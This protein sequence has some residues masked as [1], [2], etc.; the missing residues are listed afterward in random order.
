MERMTKLTTEGYHPDTT[1][2]DLMSTIEIIKLMNEEDKKIPLAIAKVL[3]EIEQA[4]TAVVH[5]LKSGGRL[6]YVGAGTSGR[7]GLLDA[8]E[9][10]P[11]F[12]T[13]PKLVQAILAGGANA[14]MI[15]IEGAE[16][17]LSLGAVELQ[18][19][20]LTNRDVVIGI[21]ASGRTPF[22]KGALIYAQQLG[23]KTISLV[24]NAHS[25]ISEHADIAIEVI[26][27]PEILTGST[28]LK[29]AT[30][31]KQI[32]NMITTTTMIKLGKVYKNL[33]VDVHASNF[34]L[35]ERAKHIVCE[36]TGASYSQAES[37]LEQNNYQVKLAIVVLL[38]NTTIEEATEL[39][40]QAEGHV[41]RAVELRKY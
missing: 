15:A 10:P 20:Q 11:T 6:F 39:L 33:M 35:R 37:V 41:R 34:K 31:H 36:V 7:I 18:K 32:L 16:D 21:A 5:A 1:N 28:R 12:S 13:S 22:V 24:S 23:A 9:C 4:I 30:A 14:V 25:V 8:V 40:A 19:Q 3:P 2:L 29:A 38:T 27:G 26:T 17:D